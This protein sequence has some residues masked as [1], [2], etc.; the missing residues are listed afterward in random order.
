MVSLV[1]DYFYLRYKVTKKRGHDKRKSN[2]FYVLTKKI[3][4]GT[5]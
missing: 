3:L 2:I 1:L 4:M 5:A